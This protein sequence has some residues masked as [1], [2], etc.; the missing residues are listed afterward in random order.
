MKEISLLLI[1]LL[2]IVAKLLGRGGTKGIIA[3]NLLL[4]Q[5]LLVVCRPRQRAPNLFPSDR[6]L[7]GFFSLFLRP[8]RIEKTAVGIRP[9]TLLRFHDYLVRRKYRALFSPHHKG[10]PGPKGPSQELIHTIVELKHRNPRFGY[11]RIARIISKTF[12]IEIDRNVVRRVL[13][14]YYRPQY[15][16]NG[17]S[18][19][20]F[21]GHMK[22]SLWSID[23][24]RCESI[25]LK[26]H[27]VL[28][29]MDQFTRRIIGFAVYAGDV[30]GMIL[31]Q[32]FSKIIAGKSPPR[33][34]SSDNDPL[35]EY[36]RWQ[37]NLRVLEVDE[38]KTVPHVPVS[39]PF[40]ERLIGTIRREFLDQ[41]LFWNSLDLERKLGEFQYYYNQKRV[42]A[43]LGGDTP[44]E[45][46]GEPETQCAKINDF[47]WQTHCR[48][49]VQL[50][51]AA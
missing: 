24:F 7:F 42:H 27:W 5:Q 19:L 13:A 9:S 36:H 41:M 11:P 31:C 46:A 38:I 18:W 48:G 50:P 45:V 44:A 29:V 21:L 28:V 22:D 2:T 6:F 3:E 8:G 39:H 23:L 49:L 17:P 34:L 26:S 25:T 20:A 14:K 10:K 4:K 33:Y 47:R 37:A 43:S 12:G 16:G 32:M 1:H 51:L 30:N 15:G 40:V 35:F